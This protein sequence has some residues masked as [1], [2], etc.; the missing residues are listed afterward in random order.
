M[1]DNQRHSVLGS[2]DA[3]RQEGGWVTARTDTYAELEIGLHRAEAGA[4]AVEL[5]FTDPESEAEIAPVRGPVPIDP[6]ELLAL[7]LDPRTYGEK[8]AEGLFHDAEVRDLFRQVKTAVETGELCLRLRLMVGP[9]AP[10]LH[11]LRWELLCDPESKAP[12]A[13]SEKT[14]LSRFMVSRDW[15]HVRP[16]PRA[17]LT[18]LV[19]VAAPSDA[20]TFGLAEVDR[21]GEIDRARRSLGAIEPAVMAERVTLEHLVERLRNGIDIIYLVCHGAASRRERKALLYLEDEDGKTA[22][23]AAADLAERVAELERP[24]RLVVLASC[25]SGATDEGA[26]VGEAAQSS[27]APLLADAGVPAIVAMQGRISMATIEKAMPIFFARLLEDGQIDRAMAIARGAVRDRPDSWMPALYL[28]LKNG[29]LWSD[30]GFGGDDDV[31]WKNL[32]RHVRGGKFIPI[33]GPGVTEKVC[34]TASE[35]ARRLAAAHGFPLAHQRADLPRLLQYLS[36]K[37][38]PSAVLPELT[39][40]L[41]RQVLEIHGQLL[42]DELRRATLPRLMDAVGELR[43]RD[44]D[45]PHRVL[46]ELPASIYVTANCDNLLHRALEAQ[47]REPQRL[48]C[49]WRESPPVAPGIVGGEEPTEERPA[50]YH[51]LGFF[52][53]EDSLVLTEDDYFDYLIAA[54]SN[55]LVPG[56]VER[57]LVDRS[58]LLLGFRLTDWSFRVLFRLIMSLPGRE[59]LREHPHVAVQV[60]PEQTDL[61]DAAGARDYLER[62]FGGAADID[63]YWGSTEDFLEELRRKLANLPTEAA[64]AVEDEDSGWD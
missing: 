33:L 15:R 17:E 26:A 49:R 47:G 54:A 51:V 25:E 38:K 27:L 53:D 64:A 24:P 1:M 57:S 28:R 10:E 8:L 48:V 7:Q 52:G 63:V 18:V 16:R 9:S 41:H 20:G 43:R 46:A 30:A 22:P 4:Y 44:P 34:L 35:T 50:L 62:Y 58:L 3:P 60:D 39:E 11:A 59:R 19:A 23:T 5:R 6:E 2:E 14:L 56:V 12:L 45:E 13:T 32:C 40:Q 42:I 36:V 21:D 61:A 29:R 37:E 55:D 31:K